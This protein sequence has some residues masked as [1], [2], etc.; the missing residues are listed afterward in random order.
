MFFASFRERSM[1]VPPFGTNDRAMFKVERVLAVADFKSERTY[2][3]VVISEK[4]LIN[5]SN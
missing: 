4:M 2:P 1:A 3:H 5:Q